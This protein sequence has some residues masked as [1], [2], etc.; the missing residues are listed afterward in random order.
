MIAIA[1][2]GTKGRS[3]FII[4]L[5]NSLFFKYK[6]LYKFGIIHVYA[7]DLCLTSK[8]AKTA[9]MIQAN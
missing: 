3:E 1:N 6:V 7:I 5:F 2:Q 4:E 9:D 8:V